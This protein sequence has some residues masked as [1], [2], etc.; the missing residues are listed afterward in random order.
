MFWR[1]SGAAALLVGVFLGVCAGR[2]VPTSKGSSNL[3]EKM[4]DDGKFGYILGFSNASE[5]YQMVLRAEQNGC[6]DETKNRFIRFLEENPM[7]DATLTQWKSVLDE[8]YQDPQNQKL[9][10][11]FAM[12]IASLQIAGRPQS[13]IDRQ[14]QLMRGASDKL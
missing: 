8:F 9:N 4:D 7:P 10:L 6:G 3:W 14:L 5:N 13:E 1:R 12:Q 2:Q 11:V